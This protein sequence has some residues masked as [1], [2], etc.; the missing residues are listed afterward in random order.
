L[1]DGRVMKFEREVGLAYTEQGA[2]QLFA[3]PLE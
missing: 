2:V 3:R 1:R